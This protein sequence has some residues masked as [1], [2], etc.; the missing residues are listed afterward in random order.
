MADTRWGCFRFSA[1]LAGSR[2]PHPFASTELAVGS[3]TPPT[4][5]CSATSRSCGCIGAPRVR[6]P[7]FPNALPEVSE[8]RV[9]RLEPRD[10]LTLAHD[11]NRNIP[12]AIERVRRYAPAQAQAMIDA[13]EVFTARRMLAHARREALPPL[14]RSRA[15]CATGSRG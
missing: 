5:R 12:E 11:R 9:L 4:R 2:L 7:T 6:W 13:G 1:A 15:H 3:A 10:E 14:R 8:A